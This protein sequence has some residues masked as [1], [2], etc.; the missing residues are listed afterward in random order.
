MSYRNNLQKGDR[1]V[2]AETKRPGDVKWAA[3]SSVWAG[4]VWQGTKSPQQVHV[5]KLRLVV[6]G[7]PEDVPPID[8]E[9][10]AAVSADR[11]AAPATAPRVRVDST[12]EPGALA[13]LKRERAALTAEMDA[14]NA[15][16]RVAKA[17]AERLD[18]AIAVLEGTSE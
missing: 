5:S 14:L 10:P 18:K 6:N 15:A 17:K 9:I 4:V 13:V 11:I 1:V 12:G 3:E 2:H 16:F 7:V 8:G